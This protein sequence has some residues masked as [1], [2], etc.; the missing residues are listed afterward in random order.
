V[1]T[2]AQLPFIK[3]LWAEIIVGLDN[4]VFCL[5]TARVSPLRRSSTAIFLSLFNSNE[6]SFLPLILNILYTIVIVQ[7]KR[8]ADKHFMLNVSCLDFIFLMPFKI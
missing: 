4:P 2:A 3:R 6:E 1:L 5:I 7:N 8:Y